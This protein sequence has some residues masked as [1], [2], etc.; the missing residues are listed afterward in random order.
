MLSQT[1]GDYLTPDSVL[2]SHILGD[3]SVPGSSGQLAT[4][5]ISKL[6]SSVLAQNR[7]GMTHDSRSLP[8]QPRASLR[9]NISH[10]T[11]VLQTVSPSGHQLHP[12]HLC[13]SNLWTLKLPAHEHNPAWGVL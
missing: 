11:C 13:V 6:H 9:Y 5:T 12:P 2:E 8:P 7:D 4:G 3:F 10:F 1:Q